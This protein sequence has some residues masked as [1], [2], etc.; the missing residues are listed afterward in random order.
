MNG[1]FS[2]LERVTND[3]LKI[4]CLI[5]YCLSSSSGVVRWCWVNFQCRGVLVIWNEAGQGP[6]ALAMDAMWVVWTFLLSYII[7]FLSPS[8]WVTARY[9]PKYCL[10]GPLSPKQPTNQV[11]F[12][13]DFPDAIQ[14][15]IKLFADD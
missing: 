3:I 12:I 2:N 13:N 1:N 6:T 15:C 8:L 14:F 7:Y 5:Q 4:V 9:R 11:I 10:K